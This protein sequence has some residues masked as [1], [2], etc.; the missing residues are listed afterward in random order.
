MF[1]RIKSY[2]FLYYFLLPYFMII[3]ITKSRDHCHVLPK[4][5]IK[6]HFDKFLKKIENLNTF[7]QFRLIK[8]SLYLYQIITCFEAIFS[9]VWKYINLCI[10]M[11]CMTCVRIYERLI[12]ADINECLNIPCIH[13]ACSNTIGSYTCQ[14]NPGWR[15]SNCDIG[16]VK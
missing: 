12:F 11:F 5:Q 8:I 14:C 15:G 10:I 3:A 16:T 6:R 2:F 7:G 9:H 4:I 1:F 13:G